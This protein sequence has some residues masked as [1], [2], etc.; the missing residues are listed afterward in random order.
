MVV[1]AAGRGFTLIELITVITISGLLALVVWRNIAQPVQ[2][3]DDLRR[4]AELVDAAETALSRMTRE[5]R[6]ALPNSV[7]VSATGTALELLRTQNGGRYRAAADPG[8]PSD[9]LDFT[10]TA[11]SFDILGPLPAFGG[12]AAGAAGVGDCLTGNSDCLVIFNTGQPADCTAIAPPSRSNAYCGDNLAGIVSVTPTSLQFTRSDAGTPLPF[13][14]PGQR[15]HIVDTPVSFVCDTVGQALRRFSDYAIATVQPVPP[16][17][18]VALLA[19]RVSACSFSYDPGTATR[20]GLVT[21]QL[22]LTD[23][24]ESVTLLQQVHVPNIP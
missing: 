14:S 8:G 23:Q 6:L 13:A 15:F 18:S 20:G 21:L 3:F 16:A 1:A 11:D 9:P 19:G 24:G 7:R 17:G 12:I 2:G 10:A 5:I 22:T 4:R